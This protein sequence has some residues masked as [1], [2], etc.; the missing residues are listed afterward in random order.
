MNNSIDIMNSIGEFKTETW[1]KID[2]KHI[3]FPKKKTN[4]AHIIWKN[5]FFFSNK[6]R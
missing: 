1:E 4:E 2:G 3:G 6:F 5:P